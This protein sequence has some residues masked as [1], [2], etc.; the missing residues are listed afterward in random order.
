MHQLNSKRTNPDTGNLGFIHLVNN[1]Y[2]RAHDIQNSKKTDIQSVVNSK[3]MPSNNLNDQKLEIFYT[4]II[5]SLS[6][7][8]AE[9]LLIYYNY[10]Q[11]RTHYDIIVLTETWIQLKNVNLYP[12]PNYKTIL[13]SRKD[14]RKS[15]GVLLYIIEKLKVT[16]N[17]TL[18][19]AILVLI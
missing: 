10:E 8:Y 17:E 16:Q 4:N 2:S 7:Q 5:R 13:A 19:I 9:L 18:D 6:L 11:K 12:I 14:V 1:S 3:S 15:G